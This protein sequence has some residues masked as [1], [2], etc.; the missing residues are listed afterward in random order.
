MNPPFPHEKTD[1][2]SEKYVE[3]ALEG[4]R[5][6]GKLAVILPTG[7]IVKPG[8]R[9]WRSKILKH[10]SLLAICQ[11]PDELFQP[12]AAAT[13]SFALIEKGVPHT[14]KRKTAFVRLR[15]DG[16]SLEKCARIERGPN[17]I[18]AALDAILNGTNTPGFS[19]TASVSGDMEWA[20]GAY[21]ESAFPDEAELSSAIDVLLRRLAS[22]YTR[23]APEILAQRDAVASGEIDQIVYKEYVSKR[24]LKT[25]RR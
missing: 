22:F 11:M 1:D 19:G 16:L 18:P 25:L 2:P 5:D 15:H 8:T 14:P 7:L 10:N 13:T 17:Q 3:R 4:L 9:E 12:F 23:Y 20:A 21:I 6:R 24:N